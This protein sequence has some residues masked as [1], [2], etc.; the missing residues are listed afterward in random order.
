M[1]SG[2][3]YPTTEGTGSVNFAAVRY[4][5]NGSLDNTF[6]NDGRAVIDFG[7]SSDA[8]YCMAMQEDGN[9]V[10]AGSS[11]D[12]ATERIAVI[13]LIGF[14]NEFSLSTLDTG[15]VESNQGMTPFTF[16]VTREAG[17]G[18]EMVLDFVVAGSGNHSADANDFGGEFPAGTV[19][20]TASDA[21]QTI[22]IDV[23]G[24]L[25]GEYSENFVLTLT[26]RRT[27]NT[28]AMIHSTIRDDD[29]GELAFVAGLGE[30][31]NASVLP[32]G[33]V[34]VTIGAMIHEVTNPAALLSLMI[35]GSNTAD[36]MN[37][38]GLSRSVYPNLA[39][40][41]L[42]GGAGNDTIIG[43]NFND[44]ISGGAGDDS[45]SGGGGTDRLV[46]E[47]AAPSDP[48][49]VSMVK[50]AR[51][52]LK[53]K[54]TMTGLGS[55]TIADIEEMSLAGSEGKDKIDV[56]KFRGSVT[57]SGHG[58]NDTLIGGAGNDS[59][60]GG[61][62]NDKLT[63]NGG[64]NQLAGGNGTDYVI[65][66]G[67]TNFVLT[68]STLTGLGHETLTSI[69]RAS[70]TTAN[71]S[72]R[73]DASAFLGNTILTGG[74]G[75]DTLLGGAGKDSITGGDGNDTLNGGNGNDTLDG[76]T[77]DDALV[78]QNGHDLLMGGDGQ[79]TIIGGV[80]NDTLLGGLGDDLLIGGLG[81]DSLDGESGNDTGLGGQGAAARG[82]N[83]LKNS[84]DS[85]T[86]I[87]LLNEE[88]ATLFAWE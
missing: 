77:G 53:T 26:D 83:G 50:L 20:F 17:F 74:S 63:G 52:D 75:N 32:N 11:Y 65:E 66:A 39:N 76:G 55:D 57:L 42:S 27:G 36:S 29:G 78:G 24:D 51:T 70:L 3:A 82:G 28:Y 6:D 2:Y 88:F 69:E 8:A 54:Y 87:E 45:L 9:P 81:K 13:R 43:S 22:T 56:K 46:E 61:D 1:V 67:A 37:L 84:G 80:G 15:K 25:V 33:Q 49:V 72:S 23:S 35:I 58:G 86:G 40:I 21:S 59:L 19:T 79:D 5:E 18:R 12:Y 41:V 64:T 30:T 60:D 16:T 7:G 85:L 68:P 48:A 71:T 10:I 14:N 44:V 4:N 31:V 47:I 38:T 73:I 34:Q 62:G